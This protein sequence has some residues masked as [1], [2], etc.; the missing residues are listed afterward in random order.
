MTKY[1]DKFL[2]NASILTYNCWNK[3]RR[4]QDL[5]DNSVSVIQR[6]YEVLVLLSYLENM[7]FI[8]APFSNLNENMSIFLAGQKK[9]FFLNLKVKDY[10]DNACTCLSFY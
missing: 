5:L 6:L 10:M 4:G 1:K 8:I 9:I 2:V 3:G 7:K